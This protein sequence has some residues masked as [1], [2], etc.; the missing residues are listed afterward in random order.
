M[1]FF[2]L[3]ALDI[4]TNSIKAVCGNKDLRTGEVKILAS[5]QVPCFGVRNGEIIKPEQVAKAVEE[6]VKEL[7]KKT[8]LKIKDCWATI[9]GSHIFS[10]NSQGLVSVA[11]ADQKISSEDIQRVLRAAQSVNLPKNKE[12]IDVF[13]QEFIVDGEAG[14]KDPLGLCGIRLEVKVLLACL[15]S[16]LLENLEKAIALAGLRLIDVSVTSV[17]SARAVLTEEQ[18]ELGV[19]LLEIGAGTTHVAVFEK[20]D[21]KDFAV[22]P[23]GSANITNDIAIGFR[24]EI[25]TAEKIKL[26]FAALPGATKDKQRALL[27]IKAKSTKKNKISP[28][29]TEQIQPECFI[30]PKTG[31][32][33]SLKLLD[34]IV[35]SRI[36]QIVA[37]TQKS[38]K[39][40]LVSQSLPAGVVLIGGGAN[41]PGLVEYIRQKF[42]LPCRL[43]KIQGLAD[44][45][46]FQWAGA[47]G[48][49]LVGFEEEECEDNQNDVTVKEKL[50]RVI[51]SFLP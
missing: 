40:Y 19:M 42:K 45:N 11:R 20:G 15:F 22:F 27:K 51:K 46:D 18:K 29:Q 26:N 7:D 2:T 12:V 37:E 16:P 10:L 39:K 47:L 36:S 43:G 21:L 50:K 49:L 17:A 24:T 9:G 14:I 4:G 44:F 25:S 35:E 6:T 8:N 13:P 5:S 30:M 23:V 32:D 38:M 41:L 31:V 34:N 28:E 48:L 1:K 33:F 3:T